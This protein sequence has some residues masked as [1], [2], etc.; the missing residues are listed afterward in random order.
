MTRRQILLSLPAV[1]TIG[2]A[3]AG[4]R[5]GAPIRV[6][7]LNHFGI[8]VSDTGRAVEFYQGLFGMPV[9]ARSGTTTILRV[10]A[11]PQFLSIAPVE[12][13]A[14]PRITHYCLGVDGFDVNNVLATLATHGV[15][16][17]ET[18]GPMRVAVTTRDG[19][20]HLVFG[21]PDG[22]VCQLQDATYCGGS[23]PL[24]SRCAAT[25]PSPTKGLIAIKD[26]NHLTIASTDSQRSNSFYRDL[27]GF[28]IRSYQGPTAPTLAVGTATQFLMFAS[29]G[30]GAQATPRRAGINHACWSLDGF[31]PETI[32]KALDSYG[33]KPRES[34]QTPVAPLRHYVTMRMENRGGAPGGTPELYF[35]DPDGLVIQL[36]DTRYCG[37]SGF[38]GNECPRT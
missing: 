34:A 10:G 7:A 28:S 5:G 25:Q 3:F 29:G 2:A 18:V 14:P 6:R 35:T 1:G 33:L 20:S 37:G 17:A 22:I 15:R 36:Q 27:F 11:G 12:G 13:N 24:G 21:D 31:T 26:L 19:R 30:G 38:L 23:G 9:Q 4:Q 8:A 16:K 32:L